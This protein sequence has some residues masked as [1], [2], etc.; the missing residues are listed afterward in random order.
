MLEKIKSAIICAMLS[1]N[2][3]GWAIDFDD[4]FWFARASARPEILQLVFIGWRVI[5]PIVAVLVVNYLKDQ[6]EKNQR[7]IKQLEEL[8][9]KA[10]EALE[11]YKN[12]VKR[13]TDGAE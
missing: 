2:F 7:K 5:A 11:D 13:S 6:Y 12:R 4:N 9:K 1:A 3:A 8:G 10:Q